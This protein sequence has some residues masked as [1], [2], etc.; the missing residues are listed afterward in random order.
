MAK[1]AKVHTHGRHEDTGVV[2]TFSPGEAIPEEYAESIT[3]P[4][5]YDEGD[6]P[7]SDLTVD[8]LRDILVDRGLSLSGNKPDLIERLQADD[9]S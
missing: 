5:A 9:A 8:Q 2:R 6:D 1:V 3:N 4:R 7:Y